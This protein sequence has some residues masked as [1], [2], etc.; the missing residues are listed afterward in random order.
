MLPWDLLYQVPDK[1]TKLLVR[2]RSEQDR[3][4]RDA[5]QYFTDLASTLDAMVQKLDR[6]EVP[7]NEGH[8]FTKLIKSFEAKTAGISKKR[9]SDVDVTADD[10]RD[11]AERASM[12]DTA[13]LVYV[14]DV[15]IE[16]AEWLRK[17][18]GMVGDCKG[19]ADV[20]KPPDM[21]A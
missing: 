19:I 12:M 21:S 16:R 11:L 3:R 6:R 1:L 9:Q 14:P 7:H 17:M 13:L 15:E 18:K 2:L 5:A 10:L 20:L 8:E 4:D